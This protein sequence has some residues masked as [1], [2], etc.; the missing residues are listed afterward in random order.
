MSSRL[1]Q[2]GHSCE[3]V[4]EQDGLRLVFDGEMLL[5]QVSHIFLRLDADGKLIRSSAK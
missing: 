4:E 3:E 5:Y 2:I 1:K